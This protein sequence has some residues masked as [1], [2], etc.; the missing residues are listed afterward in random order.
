MGGLFPS[1]IAELAKTAKSA[2]VLYMENK[3][4]YEKIF[5]RKLFQICDFLLVFHM[6]DGS[7]FMWNG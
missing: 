7:I 2:K 3:L 4:W 5:C 6:Y 1:G